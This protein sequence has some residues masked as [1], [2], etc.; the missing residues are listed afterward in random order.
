M[1]KPKL[2][3]IAFYNL[4]NF[5]DT[6]ND[7][8]TNDDAFTPKGIMHW[9]R[10]RFENKA[11]KIAKSISKIGFKETHEPPALIGLAEVE[12]KRVIQTIVK[13]GYLRKYHYAYVHYESADKRGMDV[14][15]L[16]RKS[17]V[18][19]KAQKVYPVILYN[20][21]GEAY[22]TRDILYVK[23]RL[24]GHVIHLYIN[25]WPSRREGALESNIKRIQA[26]KKLEKII[27]YVYYEEP[28]ANIIVMGDFNTDP[29]DPVLKQLYKRLY[30]PAQEIYKQNKGSLNHHHYWHLFDQI[31]F[32]HNMVNNAN[33]RFR[34]FE[35]FAPDFLK[36]KA[37][38][39]HL[40]YR[41]Y[42]GRHY[43]GGYSDHFPVFALLALS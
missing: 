43:T 4:E 12:N 39:K 15:L 24:A 17:L 18:E 20:D 16:Y 6:L 19:I 40:P 33:F 34:K 37:N 41:T 35:V 36:N 10:K 38:K 26:V 2:I 5:F 30:N 8:N 27:D 28:T 9:V 3:S 22:K 7:P 32:S 42:R 1:S 25:H 21:R 31:M 14:A 23:A 11:K 29:D 13:Q